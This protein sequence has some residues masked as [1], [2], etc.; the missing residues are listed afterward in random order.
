LLTGLRPT[1]EDLDFWRDNNTVEV[2]GSPIKFER[3]TD[4]KAKVGR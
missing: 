2:I 4:V 3:S 1:L